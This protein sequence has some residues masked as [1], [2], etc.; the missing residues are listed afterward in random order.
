MKTIEQNLP[1]LK[2][3]CDD[4][5]RRHLEMY[6]IMKSTFYHIEEM[7]RHELCLE[8]EC[9][10]KR[11]AA[12]QIRKNIGEYIDLLD[13]AVIGRIAQPKTLKPKQPFKKSR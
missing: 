7:E 13:A 11:G 9:P 2:A 3:V 5:A 1:A 12:K 8:F 6:K 4:Q 10:T